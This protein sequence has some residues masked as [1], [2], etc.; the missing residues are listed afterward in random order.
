M[1]KNKLEKSAFAMF[2]ENFG[3]L[4]LIAFV[5]SILGSTMVILFSLFFF[6]IPSNK[7]RLNAFVGLI[8]INLICSFFLL[9]HPFDIV[10]LEDI[11]IWANTI[12]PEYTGG[13]GEE[14]YSSILDS[15]YIETPGGRLGLTDIFSLYLFE[16]GVIDSSKL[17]LFFATDFIC[18]ILYFFT[19]YLLAPNE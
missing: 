19:P 3:L 18:F 8:I 14:V 16:N 15:Y 17:S 10:F 4:I 9:F 6:F 5:F 13:L 1:E 2:L 11:I 7:L 12:D